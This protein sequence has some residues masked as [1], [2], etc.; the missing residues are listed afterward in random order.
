MVPEGGSARALELPSLSNPNLSSAHGVQSKV[1]E[2]R[3]LYVLI[4]SRPDMHSQQAGQ[5][6]SLLLAKGEGREE[7]SQAILEGLAG[8][9]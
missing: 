7:S 2:K 4:R 5:L 6:H 8:Q 9:R 1:S 3:D